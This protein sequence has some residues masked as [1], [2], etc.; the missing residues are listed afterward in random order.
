MHPQ[1]Q[2]RTPQ[3]PQQALLLVGLCK[4]DALPE[5]FSGLQAGCQES[6]VANGLVSDVQSRQSWSSM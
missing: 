1:V 6:R 3:A 5:Q 2:W 4:T